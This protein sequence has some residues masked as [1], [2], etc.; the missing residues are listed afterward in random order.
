MYLRFVCAD[1]VGGLAHRSGILTAAYEL[2]HSSDLDQVTA[3]RL[4]Q[5]LEYFRSN[6]SVPE[7]FNR[8]KS[9][10]YYR[11]NTKGLSWFK[12]DAHEPIAKAFELKSLLEENGLIID[13][14]RSDKVGYILYEDSVQVVAE[15][16]SDTSK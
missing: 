14:V 10:G 8:T 9:K 1:K 7:R 13:I 2:Q 6:V 4:E 3:E 11:R 5:L 12:P 16:F 15:P